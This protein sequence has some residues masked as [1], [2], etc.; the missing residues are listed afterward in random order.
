MSASNGSK[1]SQALDGTV[2]PVET[3]TVT[4]PEGQTARIIEAPPWGNE[5]NLVTALGLT[6]GRPV[7][8]L[9]GGA[10]G[11]DRDTPL[12]SEQRNRLLQLFGRGLLRAA[13][14]AG[15]T[16][17]DGGTNA[18]VMAVLGTAARSQPRPVVLVGVAPAGKVLRPDET[19]PGADSRTPL[20]PNHTHFVLVPGSQWGE[21]A[22]WLAHLATVVAG[23]EGSA[24]VCVNGGEIALADV[25]HSVEA[26]RPVVVLD[27]S[28]RTADALAAAVRGEDS[29]PVVAE[30]AASGW[31]HAVGAHDRNALAWLLDD[32]LAGRAVQ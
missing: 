10:D 19:S 8:L 22:P 9:V 25:R 29:D 7:L 24:T 15:A 14:A 31:V 16:V 18:G 32:L 12:Q 4:F 1:A 13:D 28:G 5:P 30:L 21:E 17:V 6:P 23:D 27:G 26:R 20:E 2:P 3:R 11:F